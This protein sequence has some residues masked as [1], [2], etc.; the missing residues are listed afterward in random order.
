MS[1]RG[2]RKVVE[3]KAEGEWLDGGGGAGVV[4]MGRVESFG[5]GE[6]GWP[7]DCDGGQN[8]THTLYV[9]HVLCSP[10]CYYVSAAHLLLQYGRRRMTVMQEVDC[11]PFDAGHR[12]SGNVRQH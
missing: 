3:C 6:N 1:E 11:R 12:P 2:W 9:E 8:N 7:K 10:H 5:T 4:L